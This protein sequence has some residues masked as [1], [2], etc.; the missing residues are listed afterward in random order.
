MAFL[1]HT[2]AHELTLCLEDMSGNAMRRKRVLIPLLWSHT[3][4]N[5]FIISHSAAGRIG[6][7]I[8]LCLEIKYGEARE[9][10]PRTLWTGQGGGQP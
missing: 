10:E 9:R 6:A 5:A 8:E 4:E 1:L 7:I 3:Q 2:E